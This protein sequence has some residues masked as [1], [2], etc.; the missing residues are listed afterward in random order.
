LNFFANVINDFKEYEYNT[1]LLIK[2]Y[3]D[4]ESL[5]SY[6]TLMRDE[7]KLKQ[8]LLQDLQKEISNLEVM[9]YNYNQTMSTYEELKHIELGLKELKQLK[10]LITEVSSDN[11]VQ[12]AEALQRFLKDLEKNYDSRLGLESKIKLLQI[13]IE[14]LNN[15]IIDNQYHLRLQNAAAPNLV[16]LYAKGLT[17][18][19]II[20]I[21]ELVLAL[22]N[23][24]SLDYKS[25]RK[26]NEFHSIK[27][28]VIPRNEF[29]KLVIKKFNDLA[30]INSE[31]VKAGAHLKEIEY[32]KNK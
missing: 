26:D 13:E 32:K 30:G 18:N 25:I 15:K 2:E 23:S 9:S 16:T 17:N 6:V 4:F 11:D 27:I 1:S 31:M 14:R 3:K 21:T 19:D 10:G 28:D 12:P 7:I 22:E 5:R 24:Y 8:Q 20:D 29:W